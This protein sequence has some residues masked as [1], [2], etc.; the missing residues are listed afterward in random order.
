MGVRQRWGF[1]CCTCME[2]EMRCVG[3][4]CAT[5]L[6]C[7]APHAKDHAKDRERLRLIERAMRIPTA[8]PGCLAPSG[9]SQLAIPFWTILS[10]SHQ[11]HIP[12]ACVLRRQTTRHL[13]SRNLTRRNAET[14]PTR[15]TPCLSSGVQARVN[16]H[17][18]TAAHPVTMTEHPCRPSAN[19]GG[20]VGRH[21]PV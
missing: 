10:S 6:V 9:T 3:M 18:P 8:R 19:G 17:A 4:R 13:T 21:R 7:D 12:G 5:V 14:P 2:W 11:T 16:R 15:Q 20:D 1:V